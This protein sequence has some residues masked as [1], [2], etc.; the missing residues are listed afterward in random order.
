MA[1]VLREAGKRKP[2][3]YKGPYSHLEEGGVLSFIK[4]DAIVWLD[5]SKTGREEV[6]QKASVRAEVELE[7]IWVWGEPDIMVPSGMRKLKWFELTKAQINQLRGGIQPMAAKTKKFKPKY[8]VGDKT[9]AGAK[10]LRVYE[11]KDRKHHHQR[12]VVECLFTGKRID[13]AVQDAFQ[14][15]FHESVLP[16]QR[17]EFLGNGKVK[18][19]K[20]KGTAK[21]KKRKLAKA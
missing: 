9:P 4:D 3:Y 17:K 20:A 16:A 18:P 14:V 2:R 11:D 8:K 5:L 12:L 6:V 15:K 10:V 1:Y 13:I 7:V 21:G 19:K